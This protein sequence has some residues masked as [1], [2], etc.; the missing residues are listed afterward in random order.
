MRA[1]GFLRWR[2]SLD[3]NPLAFFLVVLL[4]YC[5]AGADVRLY[6]DLNWFI[7][8]GSPFEDI[9]GHLVENVAGWLARA[10]WVRSDRW[11]NFAGMILGTHL[12]LRVFR[13]RGQGWAGWLWVLSPVPYRMAVSLGSSALDFVCFSIAVYWVAKLHK[14]PRRSVLF[15][16]L[17]LALLTL[18]RPANHWLVMAVFVL[19]LA[20]TAAK[21]A[22]DRKTIYLAIPAVVVCCFLPAKTWVHYGHWSQ[23]SWTCFNWGRN[24][25][26]L[27]DEMVGDFVQD[28]QRAA[29]KPGVEHFST[30]LLQTMN[31]S[32]PWWLENGEGYT[33]RALAWRKENL[34][35]WARQTVCQYVATTGPPTRHPYSDYYYEFTFDGMRVM[36]LWALVYEL[37][38]WPLV[39][40]FPETAVNARNAN[41][42][43]GGIRVPRLTLGAFYFPVLCLSGVWLALR[44]RDT[45]AMLCSFF[46]AYTIAIPS[47]VDGWEGARMR[48]AASGLALILLVSLSEQ[49]AGKLRARYEEVSP[50]R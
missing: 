4:L 47:L 19:W 11:L 25:P 7:V 37:P 49:V 46:V 32:N 44:R 22:G 35:E 5:G 2:V 3:W 1:G 30:T 40:V 50:L 31:W 43:N 16:G 48:A 34:G 15:A 29:F 41:H 10:G 26:G 6:G 39:E 8:P 28:Q 27:V 12:L 20:A 33:R 17:G 23:G 9:T 14:V 38:F 24:V 18:I 45:V 21:A 42:V 36:G 13:E